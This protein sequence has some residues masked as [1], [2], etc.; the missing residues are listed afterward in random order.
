MKL[1][2]T[3]LLGVALLFTACKK[4]EV[5]VIPEPSNCRLKELLVWPMNPRYRYTLTYSYEGSRI[6]QIQDSRGKYITFEYT[7][8]RLTKKFHFTPGFQL[9]YAYESISYNGD[10][11][12]SAI[13]YY[14]LGSQATAPE[15]A[16]D[17]VF[18]YSGGK[19]VN[20]LSYW[21]YNGVRTPLQEF[22][23]TYTGSNITKVDYTRHFSNDPADSNVYHY[24]EKEN[25]LKA[26][27]ANAWL[28][29]S[30]WDDY[31][32]NFIDDLAI[33]R[34]L[35]GNNMV[36]YYNNPVVYTV[37]KNGNITGEFTSG[38]LTRKYIYECQ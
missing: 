11:T 25:Y 24:D 36:A 6:A 35:S 5:E 21:W 28:Y 16:I 9:P 4:Q 19:M 3:A 37:D 13:E 1:Q 38:D 34:F 26:M 20:I 7:G 22:A 30:V 31:Y 27:G 12:V 18:T 2:L 8:D 32:T 14:R 29:A 10:G 23:F 15:K 17:I 33:A